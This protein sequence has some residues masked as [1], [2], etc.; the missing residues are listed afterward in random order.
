MTD[1]WLSEQEQS[2]WRAHLRLHREL[3][4]RLN[5]QLQS[6]S[7]LSL[8]DYEVLV[9]LSEAPEGRMRPFEMLLSMQWEQSRLSHQLSRM[10]RRGLVCREEC[11]AD[12]RG[13]FIVLTACGRAAVEAAAPGHAAMVRELFIDAMTP[14]QIGVLHEL[15]TAALARIEATQTTAACPSAGAS[16]CPTTAISAG[17][18]KASP[19][20]RLPG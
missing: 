16:D 19:R 20:V 17:V 11:S 15:S 8:P 9:Q 6:D 18:G 14:E 10:Q 12:G 2:A 1:R 5:R 4:A 13:A 7:Q 3:S